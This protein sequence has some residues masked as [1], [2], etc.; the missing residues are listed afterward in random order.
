MTQTTSGIEP[1]FLPVYTRRRK[2]NPNDKNT[3]ATIIDENGD[4]FEEYNVFHPKFKMWCEIKGYNIDELG[5]MKQSELEKIVAISPYYKATSAD[6]DWINKVKMQGEI[7]KWVDHS[8]SCCLSNDTLID[9]NKGL[10]Y[11]DELTN[12]D[13]IKEGEFK[14]NNSFNG[15]IL[16]HENKRVNINSFY[17]NGIKPIFKVELKNGLC[18]KCTANEKLI[19]LDKNDTNIWTMVSDLNVGDRIKLK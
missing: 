5:K 11:L 3:K 2:I 18:I 19:K 6:V 17:N 14:I 15:K 16:N 13:D 7:Q 1:C 4:S 9:T 12:F 8:I 10:F